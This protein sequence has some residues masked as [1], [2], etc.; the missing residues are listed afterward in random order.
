MKLF[1]GV[2]DGSWFR[3]LSAQPN[4]EEVNFWRPSGK[5]FKA[6]QTG[7][8]FLFKLHHPANII[9]GG[10][11]FARSLILPVGLAWE[12]FGQANGAS[13]LAEVKARIGQYRHQPIGQF[14]NPPIGCILLAEPFFLSQDD[15]IEVPSDFAK[16]IVQGKTYSTETE[17]GQAL[18]D[19]VADRLRRASGEISIT[20]A[21]A[22]VVQGPRYGTPRPVAPRLGQGTFRALVTEAYNRRCAVTGERTLPVLEAAHIRPYGDGGEHALG[23]GLLL[24]SDLHRLY[25]GGYVTVDPIE[26]R[27]LVSGRIRE[28][29][30]NGRHYYALEGQRI[31]QPQPGFAP[32]DVNNLRYHA[33]QIY[34]G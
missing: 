32:P 19:Q 24:R 3:H 28:E 9:V 5:D 31:A 17:V 20:P 25:D 4:L 33:E 27:L 1:V 21:V 11:F 18:Y 15:W 6:L 29:F 30:E 10:G 26:H 8:L 14:D 16:N 2:T 34:R 12:A 22:A 23:N 7:E 13:T